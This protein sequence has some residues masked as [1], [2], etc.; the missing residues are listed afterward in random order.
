MKIWKEKLIPVLLNPLVVA[1]LKTPAFCWN[2]LGVPLNQRKMLLNEGG[3]YEFVRDMLDPIPSTYSFK[4]GAY[5]YPL[6]CPRVPASVILSCT[7][8]F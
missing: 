1:L 4:D 2:T 3:I 5:F 6:V 8:L 7:R